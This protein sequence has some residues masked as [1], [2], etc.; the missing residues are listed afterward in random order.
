MKVLFFISSSSLISHPHIYDI[1]TMSLQYE[2]ESEQAETPIEQEEDI[3]RAQAVFPVYSIILIASLIAVSLCQFAV[4]GAN[5]ILLGGDKSILRA[6][7][8]KPA[9]AGGEYW[10]ILTGAALHGG[11]LHLLL[12]CYALYVLGKLIETLSSR[13]HLVIVFLLSA[14]GGNVLSLIFLPEGVS[15]GASGGIV[16]FLGYLAVYGFLRRKL[17]SN[18]FLKNM[19]FNIGFIALYGIFLNQTVDNFGHLGGLITGAIYGFVQIPKDLHRDPR[20]SGNTAQIAGL[21]SLGIFI[22]VCAFSVLLIFRVV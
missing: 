19:L 3:R 2:K 5:S 9:F 4:D 22:A 17:L 18:A 7:F 16:G 8:L 1:F 13:A 12:N 6:G 20:A 11:L 10:R 14:F 21:F 15:V